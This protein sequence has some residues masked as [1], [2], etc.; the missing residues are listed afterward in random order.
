MHELSIA[1]SIVDIAL[2]KAEEASALR[3]SLVELDIGT[4]SGIEFDSLKFALSVASK[5]SLL[6]ETHFKFNRIEALC[7]CRS[8][9]N[10]CAPGL[11]FRACPECGERDLEF[12]RGKELQIKSLLI[13]QKE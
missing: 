10:L 7:E 13:D 1:I 5:D 8:C 12:I 2:R 11:D 9:S 4:L 3:V 6:E